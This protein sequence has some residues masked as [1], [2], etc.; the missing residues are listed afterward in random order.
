MARPL[1]MD[2]AGGWYHLTSRGNE[3][4]R[5]FRNDEDRKHFLDLLGELVERF[6][7]RIHSYVLM[8]N[9]YHLQVETV[10]ANLSV[11]MHWLQVSYS[12]WYNRR[13]RRVGHLF[14]GRFKAIVLE[15][16][17]WGVRLS[18]YVH[19]NPARIARLQLDKG[20]RARQAAGVIRKPTAGVI[21][22]RLTALRNYQWS[23]YRGYVGLDKVPKWLERGWI[24]GHMGAKK[25]AIQQRKYRQEA[26]R[27]IGAKDE[28][29]PWDSLVGGLLLGSEEWVEQI[30]SGLVGTEKE[31]RELRALKKRPTWKSVVGALEAVKGERCGACAGAA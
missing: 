26:E 25:K 10:E 14:Q 2:V 20:S 27:L 30:R 21:E 7:W 4:G 19:L 1:R 29:S 3:R 11:G 9:H 12:V 5:I 28:E 22:E 16:E 31:Q 8:D 17:A 18:H 15:P 13:H 6:R 24:L 23:S